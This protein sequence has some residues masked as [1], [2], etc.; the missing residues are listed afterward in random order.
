M[1]KSRTILEKIGLRGVLDFIY[2]PV[3]LCCN[4]FFDKPAGLVC[5]GCWNRI[6]DLGFA[7]CSSC[8]GVLETEL[9]CPDCATEDS[10]PVFALGHFV[11]PLKEII[12]R[13]KY[14]GYKKLGVELA[15]RLVDSH[16]DELEKIRADFIVPV[17]LHSYREK[18]RGFNQAAVLSDIIGE[19]LK[20]PVE[21]NCLLKIRR[22]KDQ[23]KLD[24]VERERNI[25]GAFKLFG[26]TLVGKSVLIV[27][28]VVTTGATI[29]EAGKVLS[30]S[31]AKPV[32]V[33]TVAVAGF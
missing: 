17:P 2:P 11:D 16:V 22:T 32:A 27:D 4:Q 28:D 14:Q 1:E 20:V 33:C 18:S 12:H 30:D 3:C 8:R 15:D 13:F 25:K 19:R 5:P 24:P 10:R 6:A 21:S 26:D 31:G 9:T 23:A 29:R 7:F